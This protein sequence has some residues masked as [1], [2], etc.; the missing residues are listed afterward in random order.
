M[1]GSVWGAIGKGAGKATGEAIGLLAGALVGSYFFGTKKA[2]VG[3]VN[4]SGKNLYFCV[5]SPLANESSGWHFLRAGGNTGITC[6][7][8]RRDHSETFYLHGRTADGT[9]LW[10][11]DLEFH[12][13][14]PLKGDLQHEN[15]RSLNEFEIQG[16]AGS[17]PVIIAAKSRNA[18]RPKKVKGMRVTISGDFTFRFHD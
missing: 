17:N 12:A 13:A 8:P 7:I 2:T 4:N 16:A 14:F 15:D 3:F 9:T 10:E 18:G 6:G 11:G 5:Y 1:S